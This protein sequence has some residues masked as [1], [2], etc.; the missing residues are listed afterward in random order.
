MYATRSGAGA[1]IEDRKS[2]VPGAVGDRLHVDETSSAK[3]YI[4]QC[5]WLERL[6]SLKIVVAPASVGRSFAPAA[7]DLCRR[8]HGSRCRL[9]QRALRPLGGHSAPVVG[10]L[11]FR[12]G[13]PRI[14]D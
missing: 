11:L 14:S 3:D 6:V 5:A 4:R 2:V 8:C 1:S 13:V 7:L 10:L 12:G 9:D